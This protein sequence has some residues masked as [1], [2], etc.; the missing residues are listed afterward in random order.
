MDPYGVADQTNMKQSV[1]HHVVMVT[2]PDLEAGRRVA[3]AVLEQRVA[4]CVNIVP[5]LESHY[6]WKGR[7]TT[8]QELLL[9]MKTTQECL[10]DLE[11]TVLANHPYD[12]PEVVALSLA[13][14][15]ERYLR[16]LDGEVREQKELE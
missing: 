8:D 14:G 1:R 6:W 9:I 5:G 7:L 13:S 16:W 11:A 2:V 10:T 12:T 4:A 3:R 15:S